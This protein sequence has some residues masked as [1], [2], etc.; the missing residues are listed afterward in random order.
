MEREDLQVAPLPAQ[1]GP[2]Q[3]SRVVVEGVLDVE[4][5]DEPGTVFEFA[6][7]LA[8]EFSRFYAACQILS[9]PDPALRASRLRIAQL[10]LREL[11]LMLGLLGIEV[12]ERM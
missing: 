10:T 2:P 1:N 4:V 12:P 3:R 8:Q 5:G 6:F 9:E 11:E 7:A